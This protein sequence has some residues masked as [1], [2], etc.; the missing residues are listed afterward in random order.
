MNKYGFVNGEYRELI[1]Y[2]NYFEGY[3]IPML[4][5]Y[6]FLDIN[7]RDSYMNWCDYSLIYKNKRYRVIYKQCSGTYHYYEY[8]QL[9]SYEKYNYHIF[10]TDIDELSE[11][12]AKNLNNKIRQEKI[13][14][15]LNSLEDIC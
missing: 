7:D 10:T 1:S 5:K 3:A 6:G 13:Y 15:F 4:A 8:E 14:K 11:I 9:D 2:R 12:I